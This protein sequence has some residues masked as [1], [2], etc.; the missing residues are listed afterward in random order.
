MEKNI[1]LKIRDEVAFRKSSDGTMVIVSPVTDEIVTINESAAVLWELID[2]K[3][4]V[5]ALIRSFADFFGCEISSEFASV[6]KD[7]LEVLEKF[8]DKQFIE[9]L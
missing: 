1:V 4:D 2:G 7:A 6:E 9:I 8:L 5:E 3:R